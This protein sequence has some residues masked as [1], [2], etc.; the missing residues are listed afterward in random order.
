MF[1]DA[2][3]IVAILARESGFERLIERVEAASPLWTSGLSVLEAVLAL[4]RIKGAPIP[5]AQEAV[6]TFLAQASVSLVPVAE[7]ETHEA[8]SAYARY[9][10]GQGHPAQLNLGDCFSYACARTKR[11]PLLFVGNDFSRTDIPSALA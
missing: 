8:V 9:G 10:K 7:P 1:L 6:E 5:V 11:V 4:H 3:A 2:S